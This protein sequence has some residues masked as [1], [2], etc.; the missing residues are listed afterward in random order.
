MINL[1]TYEYY[2]CLMN[3]IGFK[4]C[5]I[6]ID[7]AVS[8]AVFQATKTF[9]GKVNS[10]GCFLM[11]FNPFLLCSAKQIP[12]VIEQEGVT[13]EVL[14]VSGL[15]W[16]S[17]NDITGKEE[18]R[19]NIALDFNDT[20]QT[21]PPLYSA[22]R[23]VS[24]SL[25]VYDEGPLQEVT[26]FIGGG[27]VTD[28]SNEVNV[29]TDA[30]QTSSYLKRFTS[31]DAIRN[32]SF[33]R[34]RNALVGI[35]LRYFPLSNREL[36]YI[37]FNETKFSFGTKTEPLAPV[38]YMHEGMDENFHFVVYGEGLR[39]KN[40]NL[41][42]KICCNYECLVRSMYAPFITV[43]KVSTCLNAAVRGLIY[44]EIRNNN[45]KI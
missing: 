41:K 12:Y 23:L 33:S 2:K 19:D 1:E 36:E 39:T 6:P 11:A 16:S 38:F 32:M 4:G 13:H 40:N 44:N 8:S 21:I 43:K 26:G 27:I 35:S 3:P 28:P 20:L 9:Q 42:V 5:R 22:Y 37:P 10:H 25:E 18:L 17:S 24:A 30:V 45:F 7:H 15:L 14:N 34:E 29:I 31:F